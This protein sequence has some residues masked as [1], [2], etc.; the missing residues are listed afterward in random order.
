MKTTDEYLKDI[1]IWLM[2]IWWA[3]IGIFIAI[4]TSDSTQA[5]DTASVTIAIQDTTYRPDMYYWTEDAYTDDI[6][7][8][9]ISNEYYQQVPG[10]EIDGEYYDLRF[11][12]FESKYVVLNSWPREWKTIEGNSR[13]EIRRDGEVITIFSK[14][15]Y[16][17][18]PIKNK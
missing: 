15:I 10:W 4:L 3:L 13:Q 8:S 1:K 2:L 11:H 6:D 16:F 17:Q 18:Q 5:Q 14:E 12:P 7:S 9:K